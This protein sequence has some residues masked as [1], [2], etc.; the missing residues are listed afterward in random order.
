[1]SDY[2][3]PYPRLSLEEPLALVGHPGSGVAQVG[4]AL[5]ATTGLAFNHVDRDAEATAGRSRARVLV[6]DGPEAL[7]DL[8]ARALRRAIG[9]RPSGVVVLGTRCLEAPGVRG[10]LP[11]ACTL[12][13]LRR[14]LDVLLR[15]IQAR[16]AEA[17][18]SL[19][20][21]LAGAPTTTDS[22]AEL[23]ERSEPHLQE[24][25]VILDAEDRHASRVA[26]EIAASLDRLV[27][28]RPL[29]PHH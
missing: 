6:E 5:C 7:R 29:A 2:Y 22:L 10:W 24:A 17:P 11:Q 27:G 12:V 8:E 9:R 13:Y 25:Q 15:R 28:A 3:D 18:A 16:L 1:M 4:H 20:E 21:F 14:P 26:D 19:P 23:L